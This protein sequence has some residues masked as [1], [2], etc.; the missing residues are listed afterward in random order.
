[1]VIIVVSEQS[2][3]NGPRLRQVFEFVKSTNEAIDPRHTVI[4]D[5]RDIGLSGQY[6]PTTTMVYQHFLGDR[7]FPFVALLRRP[8]HNLFT[9]DI[10]TKIGTTGTIQYR[11]TRNVLSNVAILL[12]L[13][14]KKGDSISHALQIEGRDCQHKIPFFFK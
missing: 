11:Y 12:F 7:C 5:Q 14:R 1:M 4:G 9:T 8:R 13:L 2:N 3:P 6:D 10:Q